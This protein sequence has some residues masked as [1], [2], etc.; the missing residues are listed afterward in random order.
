MLFEAL[1]FFATAAASAQFA[2]TAIDAQPPATQA[3]PG[4]AA[5]L[6]EICSRHPE[7]ELAFDFAETKPD[8]TRADTFIPI[9]DRKVADDV[10]SEADAA[11][12]EL[13]PSGPGL[14][15]MLLARNSW[16]KSLAGAQPVY[17]RPGK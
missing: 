13:F 3:G 1:F 4:L 9:F 17:V 11:Y 16:K 14:Q 15:V 7:V 2:P 10:I 6:I 8:G 5:R 12:K